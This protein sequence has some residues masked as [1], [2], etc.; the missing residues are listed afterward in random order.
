MRCGGED[1]KNAAL[2]VTVAV[3]G[4]ESIRHNI[5]CKNQ[6]MAGNAATACDVQL[7]YS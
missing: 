6:L 7:G 1:R 3:T 5:K 4:M 2:A